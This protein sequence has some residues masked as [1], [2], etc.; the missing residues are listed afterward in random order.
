LATPERWTKIKAIVG[1]ALERGRAERSAFLGQACSQD[2]ELRAEVESLLAAHADADWLSENPSAAT[3]VADPAGES[4]N[5]GPIG[6]F[7]QSEPAEWDRF[8]WQS[9]PRRCVA[10]SHSS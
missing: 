1:A 7:R 2:Q 9:R 6:S 8:G 3:T 4:K 10:A 5:I